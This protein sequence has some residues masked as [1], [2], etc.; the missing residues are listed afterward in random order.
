MKQYRLGLWLALLSTAV[1]VV[2]SCKKYPDPPPEFENYGGDSTANKAR[3]VMVISI[4][5][6]SGEVLE[7][8]A[9]PNIQTLI[10]HGKYS[11]NVLRSTVSTDASTWVTLLTGVGYAKHKIQDSTFIYNPG[12]FDENSSVPY[13]PTI[14]NYI[15][16][17][18]PQY[19]MA[20]VTPWAELA[21]YTRILNESIAVADDQAVK[22]SAVSLLKSKSSLGLMFVDFHEAE[23]AGYAGSFSA[24]DAAYKAAILKADEY[25][26]DIIKAL[27]GREN[28]EKE[29]WLVIVTTNHGGSS[30]DPEP[31]FMICSN[32]ALAKEEVRLRGFNTVHFKGS[33]NDAVNAIVPDDNGLYNFGDSEDFTIQMQIK[34]NT[35]TR[36]PGF[37]SKTNNGLH[38]ANITGWLFMQSSS[39]YGIVFGGTDNGG[40]GKNQIGTSDPVTDGTWHTLTFT[41]K[42]E[43]DGTRMARLYVD[44]KLNSSK[45][46]ASNGNLDSDGPLKLGFTPVDGSGASDFYTSGVA[47]FDVALDAATIVDNMALKDIHKHP[48]YNNL[49]GY[50]P[51]N[52]GGGT[53]LHNQAPK[54]YNMVLTGPFTWESLGVNAPP[55][56][57]ADSTVKGHV[58]VVTTGSD[59]AANILYWLNIEVKSDWNIDGQ[60]WLKNF[61]DEIYDL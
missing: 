31:G 14:F 16:P 57:V 37:F 33:G 47:I 27:K 25:I 30:S 1:L 17:S 52:E 43:D 32:E 35:N 48:D 59:V 9:P 19:N 4:D 11:Y 3:K 6:V 45:D 42:S 26:G 8:I 54:G 5:G 18:K 36:W 29:D 38:G 22:D 39:H 28:Y 7:T 41:V 56:L 49:I 20:M 24:T 21:H 10:G 50:W 13:F 51:I 2:S 53:V 46:I 23:L 61:E 34:F 15:L 58:S 12:D 55:N 40:S 60:P 44:G